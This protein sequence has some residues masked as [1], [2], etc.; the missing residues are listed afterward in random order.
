MIKN[1]NNANNNED[2]GLNQSADIL[3]FF[4]LNNGIPV[5][6]IRRRKNKK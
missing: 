5:Q 4:G 1:N 6:I 3:A 2:L